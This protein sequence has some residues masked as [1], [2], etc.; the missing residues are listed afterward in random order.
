[1]KK[2]IKFLEA[3]TEWANFKREFTESEENLKLY[4][5]VCGKGGGGELES[6]SR[7]NTQKRD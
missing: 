3:D 1:M 2:I 6:A 4:R 7:G 5:E